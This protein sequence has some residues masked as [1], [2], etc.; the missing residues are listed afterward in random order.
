ML[1]SG[2]N[3]ISNQTNSTGEINP[4]LLYLV[5]VV[6]QL[7][8]RLEYH[9]ALVALPVVPGAA[10]HGL[11]GRIEDGLRLDLRLDDVGELPLGVNV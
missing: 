9:L 3:P 2:L 6:E 8:A 1:K 11:R 10:E 5:E 7:G 4:S